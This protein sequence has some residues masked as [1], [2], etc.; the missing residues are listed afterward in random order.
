MKKTFVAL[1]IF[2]FGAVCN[3]QSDTEVTL[4]NGKCSLTL[5]RAGGMIT[6]VTLNG[7]NIN[8]LSWGLTNEQMPVN[9]RK[10]APFRGHFICLGRW[11]DPTPGEIKAGM[12]NNGDITTR[13][14]DVESFGDKR[15]KLNAQSDLDLMTAERIMEIDDDAPL[16]LIND[17][18]GNSSTVG[19]LFNIVQHATLGNPFLSGSTIVDCNASIGFMQDNW[20]PSPKYHSYYWPYGILTENGKRV[21]LRKSNGEESYVTTHLI[22]DSI[23]WITAFS[24]ESRIV[25]GYVWK[26]ADYPWVNVWHQTDGKIPVAKGLEFGTTGVGTP[27]QE[28]IEL[29]TSLEGVKSYFFFDALESVE[30]N[31][32][33]FMVELPEG[34]DGI[35]KITK[36]QG[37][38][39]LT[40][41]SDKPNVK[42]ISIKSK[43]IDAI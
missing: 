28:L 33:G 30:K 26:T 40:P 37:E 4:S 35:E 14:W 41:R 38:I 20:R 9:N 31:F 42:P 22:S 17:K 29:D 39:L 27:Y 12:P 10:G 13:I 8:P 5:D 21:D 11:G 24:P 32:I 16:F 34:C 25:L 2:G 19:R 15:I 23:G 7:S 1:L 6:S 43:L 3:A 18:V 36:A